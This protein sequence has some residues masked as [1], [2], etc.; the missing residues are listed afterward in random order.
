LTERISN[1]RRIGAEGE[2]AEADASS[3]CVLA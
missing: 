3:T 2:G 1:P